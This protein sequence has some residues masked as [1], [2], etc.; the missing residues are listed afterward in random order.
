MS[1]RKAIGQILRDL[2]RLS[3]ADIERALDFQRR[4]GGLFGEALIALKLLEPE[5]LEWSL[6]TQFDLPY[7]F[8]EAEAIDQAVAGLVSMEWALRHNALPIMRDGQRL[9]LLIDS[10]LQIDAPSELASMTGYEVDLALATPAAIRRVI[11][12]MF[13]GSQRQRM[14]LENTQ[15]ISLTQFLSRKES[16]GHLDWGISDRPDRVIGWHASSHMPGR[17]RL[18]ARWREEFKRIFEP[19]PDQQLDQPGRHELTVR[20]VNEQAQYQITLIVSEGACELFARAVSGRS[21]DEHR[22]QRYPPPEILT[23]L[24]EAL[25]DGVMVVGVEQPDDHQAADLLARLPSWLLPGGHRAAFLAGEGRARPAE[26]P[27]LPITALDNERRLLEQLDFDMLIIDQMPASGA[28]LPTAMSLAPFVIVGLPSDSGQ[29]AIPDEIDALLSARPDETG[30]Q[31]WSLHL[32][33]RS[34]ESPPT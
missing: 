27:V 8:P 29:A 18:D 3:D 33:S 6:A 16:A 19:S 9:T 22:E 7:V 13:G 34:P 30:E 21:V 24:R 5:E 23:E 31:I 32:R 26:L 12:E 28:G 17:Q 14:S 2:G 15:A 10:P 4:E 25:L 11:R 1:E 20:R